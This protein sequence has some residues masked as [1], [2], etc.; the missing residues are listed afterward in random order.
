MKKLQLPEHFRGYCQDL[1]FNVFRYKFR[2]LE[3]DRVLHYDYWRSRYRLNEVRY[4]VYNY[5]NNV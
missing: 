2:K 5:E 3:T 4:Y 1:R